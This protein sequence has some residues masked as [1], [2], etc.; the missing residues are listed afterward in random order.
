MKFAGQFQREGYT[1]DG[2]REVTFLI[3]GDVAFSPDQTYLF[4][5]KVKKPSKS[6][7]QRGYFFALLRE[8]CMKE[9]GN[10]RNF[11]DLYVQMLIMSGASCTELEGTTEALESLKGVKGIREVIIHPTGNG[12][13]VAQV[14]YGLSTFDTGEASQL[15]DTAL[16][17]ASQ[18]GIETDYWRS[19]L[20]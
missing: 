5:V 18:I 1:R 6:D 10:L 17:Y 20:S 8:I 9:D 4:D 3:N 11:E 13:G 19:L 12:R 16:F 15:I 7:A 2:Y 14:Y